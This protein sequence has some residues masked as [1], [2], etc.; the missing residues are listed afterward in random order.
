MTIIVAIYHLQRHIVPQ[1]C[2]V[3]N[4]HWPTV[5]HI[6]ES[7]QPSSHIDVLSGG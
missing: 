3:H 1:A 4:D 5:A 6:G 7:G 2:Q